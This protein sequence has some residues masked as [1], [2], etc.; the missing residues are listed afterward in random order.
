VVPPGAW[1]RVVYLNGVT[2]RTRIPKLNIDRPN[3]LPARPLD[4]GGEIDTKFSKSGVLL[5]VPL[6][7]VRVFCPLIGTVRYS[8]TAV[9]QYSSTTTSSTRTVLLAR[10][11]SPNHTT[12]IIPGTR[13]QL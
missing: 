11:H 12:S 4:S 10:S 7:G 3:A 13:V 5:L 8:S 1:S 2:L 9:L 6:L